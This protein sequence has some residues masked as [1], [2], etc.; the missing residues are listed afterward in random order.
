MILTETTNAHTHVT[1]AK[2]SVYQIIGFK[3]FNLTFYF[4]VTLMKFQ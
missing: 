2:F 4:N 1:I 3:K